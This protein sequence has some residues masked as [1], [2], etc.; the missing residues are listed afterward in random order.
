VLTS[1]VVSCVLVV[2]VPGGAA[3]A[4]DD[5]P[6]NTTAP[7]TVPT[8]A[9]SSPSPLPSTPTTPPTPPPPTIPANPNGER[10]ALSPDQTLV[11][12][13]E[14]AT[15]TDGQRALLRQLQI[16]KDTLAIRRFALVT[17]ARQVN[18]ARVRLDAARASESVARARV[19]Q[20]ADQ[21]QSVKDEIVQLA[22]AAY[23]NHTA[24]WALGAIGS[25]DTSNAN[26]LARAQTYAR[27]DAS[28]LGARVDELTA[29][30]RRL[31]AEQRVAETA[32][33]EAELSAADLESSFAAQTQAFN[34]AT[35][36]TARAQVV[37]ARGLGSGA[38]LLAQIVDPRFA[39]D[40]VTTTLAA[41]Q[42]G[43]GEP[44]ALDGVFALAIPGA[45]LN[46]P[47]GIRIDPIAGTI[48][49]HSGVDF[50]ADARTPIHAAAAGMVVVAGDCGGYGSCVVID[51]G[52]SLATVYGHQS[53]VLSQ[54][55][56]I[57]AAGQVIGLVGSTGISTGPHL[58]FEVRVHGAPIDPVPTLSG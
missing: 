33:A 27:S 20:T 14:F 17:L 35:D 13:T 7:S 46:S 18:D 6:T 47:F 52:T 37:L 24:T 2:A 11:A 53:V 9:P 32:R 22:A 16:A 42:A 1:V 38:S 15:L 40:D 8:T 48:G 43:Q 58:H 4:A 41:V 50:E 31:R 39:A 26:T 25:L 55:G 44:P 21:V 10:S 3:G 57:V 12:Q 23:R 51:H 19:E 56:D 49:F 29:L 30:E 45:R 5:P 54:V 34:D 36:A 28:L